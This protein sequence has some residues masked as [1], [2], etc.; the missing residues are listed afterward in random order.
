VQILF[1]VA[2]T[3]DPVCAIVD[4]LL[5]EFPHADAQLIKCP[6]ML[7]ANLK[8]STLTQLQ[9]R[10]KHEVVLISDADVRVSSIFLANVVQ[11]LADSQVGLV[12]SLYR[13]A[14][15]TAWPMRWEAIAVN[16]DFWSQVLQA[17]TLRP[18]DFALGAVMVTRHSDL[19]RIG[20]FSALLDYLA[21]DYQ[22]GHKIASTGKRIELC[23]IVAECWEA[24]MDVRDVLN[25][26]V[27]WARTIRV[28]QP[29]P[30]FLS[31]LSNAT[32]WP[33][34]WLFAFPTNWAL[35]VTA[36]VL[37]WRTVSAQLLQARLTGTAP[38]PLDGVL[39]LFKDVIG[40]AIWLAAFVGNK[41]SWRG[42]TYRLER[43]GKLLKL[44]RNRL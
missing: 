21:D 17:R 6:K 25:R 39:V 23:P 14:N 35:V 40:A 16:A 2:N 15:P 41:I 34:C 19:E 9:P 30:Y 33:L 5:G 37:C 42:E 10:V 13:L 1:G 20:A 22:L 18:F 31:V 32:L 28:C 4:Q 12:H 26:Q 27:R 7:G 24:P 36:I 43:G 44:S 8:V 3:D 29:L 38:S 11:P